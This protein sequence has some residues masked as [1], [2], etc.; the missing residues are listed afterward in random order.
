MLS[1]IGNVLSHPCFR[2]FRHLQRLRLPCIDPPSPIID[3][4]VPVSIT[5]TN[6]HVDC[7]VSYFLCS[8][9]LVG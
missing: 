9:P 4:L 8:L 6:Q 1:I 2:Y 5:I 7:L 3:I